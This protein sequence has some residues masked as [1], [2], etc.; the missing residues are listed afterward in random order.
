M[1]DL[2]PDLVAGLER[3][4]AGYRVE[5]LPGDASTRRFHRLYL[6][7]GGTR[8]VMDY[9]APFAGETDDVRL[10]R[11]FE[12]ARLPVARVLDVLEDAGCLLLEDLGDLTLEQALKRDGRSFA[13]AVELA[14][15]IATR[16][17]VSLAGSERASG[18]A[19]D[20]ERFGFEMRF[21][22]EHFIQGFLGG[23]APPSLE[24]ALQRL[25]VEVAGHP[26][27]MC[28]RDYHSRNIM[29]RGDGKLA[30]VDIQDARWGPDT[31][32]IASLLRDA[33]VDLD[34]TDVRESFERY[35]RLLPAGQDPALRHRF[36]LVATQ[37]MIK[38]LG[39]F[40]YQIVRLGRERYR[41]AIPRTL[42]RLDR[43]LPSS[44]T[45]RALHAELS[46]AGVF[47]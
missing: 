13:R 21:F 3:L 25:A 37:R 22:V 38:A 14:A 40:G 1:S 7:E 47:S 9:G 8:I 12:S 27:V 46:S 44:P 30:M 35:V 17:T 10:A 41:D 34:E 5:T 16:G 31:Y 15:D 4:H 39:T 24:S 29:V 18:P 45:T 33:Y 23:A 42:G 19:L 32:D 6:A 20:A 43:T 36:H 26:R 11:I 28:H 2:R